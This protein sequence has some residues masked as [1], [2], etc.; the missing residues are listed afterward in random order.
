MIKGTLQ[1]I[2]FF[3]E[4]CNL[5]LKKLKSKRKQISEKYKWQKNAI[6]VWALIPLKG[7]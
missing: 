7:R 1:E 6:L 5:D 4:M 3:P 2:T